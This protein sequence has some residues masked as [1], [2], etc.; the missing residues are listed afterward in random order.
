[1]ESSAIEEILS[2][3]VKF[4]ED[5]HKIGADIFLSMGAFAPAVG[6][7][8]TI[9]G[10]IQMLMNMTDPS[11][12]GGPMAVALLTTFYGIILANLLFIPIANKLKRRSNQELL[13]KRMMIEGVLSIQLGDN[14]RIVEHKLKVFLP[15]SLRQDIVVEVPNISNPKP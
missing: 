4:V 8:G 7:L 3:E 9:I 14:Y 5:R 11:A 10:L 1:M 12:I 15:P 6:M 2:T 13:I